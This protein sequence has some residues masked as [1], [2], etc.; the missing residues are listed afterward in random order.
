M[1]MRGHLRSRARSAGRVAGIGVLGVAG[2][3]GG[4]LAFSQTAFAGDT[5]HSTGHSTGNTVSCTNSSG[6]VVH[7]GYVASD[8]STAGDHDNPLGNRVLICATNANGQ[9][10]GGD[11]I[12]FTVWQTYSG[13]KSLSTSVNGYVVLHL[14]GV[15]AAVKIYVK[16]ITLTGKGA[17]NAKSVTIQVPSS[18][19]GSNASVTGGYFTGEVSTSSSKEIKLWYNVPT[20]ATSNQSVTG[21]AWIDPP[22]PLGSPI[23]PLFGNDGLEIVGVIGIASAATAAVVI[24]RRQLARNSAQ[25]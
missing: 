25:E 7:N 19:V 10:T 16:P 13:S 14:Q 8:H 5:G 22:T 4:T 9:V 6:T 15:S 3:V 12:T 1:R 11:F 2:A 21:H 20:G 18:S 23:A 24:R 17:S